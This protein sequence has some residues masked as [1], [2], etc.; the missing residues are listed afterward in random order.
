MPQSEGFKDKKFNL[1]KKAPFVKKTLFPSVY[2]TVNDV[3]KI[4][5]SAFEDLEKQ[6]MIQTEQLIKLYPDIVNFKVNDYSGNW[7]YDP[8][9]G[10]IRRRQEEGRD[11][12]GDV[13]VTYH[14]SRDFAD[15]KRVSV[16]GQIKQDGSL[17]RLPQLQ[18]CISAVRF[19]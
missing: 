19:N 7:T 4:L 8:D 11:T 9:T 6:D 1:N 12:I 2:A 5:P 16:L 13:R 17:E 18:T 14:L 3:I 15:G 10:I